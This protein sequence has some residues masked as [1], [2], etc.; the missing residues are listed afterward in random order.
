MTVVTP[1]AGS[2]PSHPLPRPPATPPGFHRPD[3]LSVWTDQR[4]NHC[5]LRLRGSLGAGTVSLLARHVD[6]LGCRSCDE[7]TVDLSEL[8]LLD[9]VGARLVAGLGHYVAGLGATFS[10]CGGSPYMH[11]LIAD[12]ER[13]LSG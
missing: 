9:P 5:I 7:V 4:A 1:G 2:Q 13:Q 8:D 11:A 10:V 12:A 3:Q 6:L